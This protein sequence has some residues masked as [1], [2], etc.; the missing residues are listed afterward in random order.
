MKIIVIGGVAAGMSAAA[1]AKRENKEAKIVVYEKGAFLSYSGCGMPY[2]VGGVTDKWENLIVRT[3]QKFIEAGIEPYLRHEVV[4]VHPVKKEVVVR[5]IDANRLFTDTYDKLLIATGASAI[6]PSIAGIELGNILPFKELSHSIKLREVMQKPEI[7]RVII[8]GGGYVGVEIAENLRK[9]G[10][11]VRIIEMSEQ[12]LTSFDREISQ[13]ALQ[14][15]MNKGVD[16]HLQ[17]KVEAFLGADKVEH[18]K[19]DKATYLA[20][21]VVMAIG[22]HPNT[23]FLKD[24]GIELSG[25][26]GAVIIDQQMCTNLTDIYAAGDCAQVYHKQKQANVYLPLGT[27]ANKT[28]KLAG[29]NLTGGKENYVGALGSACLKVFDLEMARTGLSE[30]EAKDRGYNYGTKVVSVHNRPAYYYENSQI[31]F[32][33][34]YEKESLLLLGAQAI[35]KQDVVWRIDLY[36]LAIH[37]G[38]TADDF[39]LV[40]FCYAPPFS[41]A[42]DAAAVAANTIK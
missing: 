23:T 17:E 9:I 19:T 33:I 34:I 3:P 16:V 27:T 37:N 2:Y 21:F 28:G 7:Q 39:G 25:E 35:G 31:T 4:E 18:V 20:D 6:W 26:N 42:W 10:K 1:K 38:M 5:D 32:K 41:G 36:A 13:K 12:L 40:D 8:V 15:I 22:I 30:N 24:S 29:V 14:E 11:E